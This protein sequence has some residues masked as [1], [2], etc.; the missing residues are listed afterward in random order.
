MYTVLKDYFSYSGKSGEDGFYNLIE[1]CKNSMLC[2]KVIL[3][4]F[5]DALKTNSILQ[6][7]GTFTPI[8]DKIPTQSSLN[9]LLEFLPEEVKDPMV[10]VFF[11]QW[12]NATNADIENNAWYVQT[13]SGSVGGAGVPV[14]L[15]TAVDFVSAAYYT[16][17]YNS[18]QHVYS[19]K[20]W[21]KSVIPEKLP[22]SD[23]KDPPTKDDV[24]TFF[25][26]L[27]TWI[28]ENDPLV[29][30]LTDL[31]DATT[32]GDAN[33][34]LAAV[35]GIS[36]IANVDIPD[37]CIALVNE[38]EA[39]N[40][41]GAHLSI[42]ARRQLIRSSLTEVNKG[43]SIWKTNESLQALANQYT[44]KDEEYW[45]SKIP[46]VFGLI[47]ELFYTGLT[48]TNQ[49]D[50]DSVR[51]SI[52]QIFKD[53]QSSFSITAY[54][55][56]ELK[57]T[58]TEQIKIVNPD[59]AM[60]D[61]WSDEIDDPIPAT[62]HYA[63]IELLMKSVCNTLQDIPLTYTKGGKVNLFAFSD[64]DDINAKTNACAF[65]SGKNATD[66][67]LLNVYADAEEFEKSNVSG[68]PVVIDQPVRPVYGVFTN[69]KKTY[70]KFFNMG[71]NIP[72]GSFYFEDSSNPTLV[73]TYEYNSTTPLSFDLGANTINGETEVPSGGLS[74]VTEGGITKAMPTGTKFREQN[75]KSV[76]KKNFYAAVRLLSKWKNLN[77]QRHYEVLY[78]TIPGKAD[79]EVHLIW[80]VASGNLDRTDKIDD[81]LCLWQWLVSADHRHAYSRLPEIL[82][83]P[84]NREI[85][86]YSVKQIWSG[87]SMQA[88]IGGEPF[89]V[90]DLPDFKIAD[91]NSTG[92]AIYKPNTSQPFQ[93]YVETNTPN[94][95]LP[96]V[97]DE[98][99]KRDT[100]KGDLSEEADLILQLF[101]FSY[102]RRSTNVGGT[103]KVIKW[104]PAKYRPNDLDD[105]IDLGDKGQPQNKSAIGINKPISLRSNN[106]ALHFKK[107]TGSDGP[108]HTS[109]KNKGNP[110]YRA[111][112]KR[113]PAGKVMAKLKDHV[114]G[115]LSK[116]PIKNSSLSATEFGDWVLEN[117]EDYV[118]EEWQEL[119]MT[120][121]DELPT[122]Q[123]WCHL[124]GHGDSGDERL[125]NF[126]SGSFHCNTEQLAM[127][128]K[129]R[130]SI[131]QS[132]PKGTYQLRS[133][134]Y[135]FNDNKALL[136][137]DYLANEAAYQKMVKVYSAL[138]VKKG[139]TMKLTGAGT[140]MPLAA[141][142][143]YKIYGSFDS[144]GE[145]AA[146]GSKVE[147]K[148]FDHIFEGQS[149]FIDQHQFN[150]LKHAAWFCVAGKD[151]FDEWYRNEVSALEAK[152]AI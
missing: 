33:A 117:S 144:D 65:P 66:S 128:S 56:Q 138:Q 87:P 18:L 61:E 30:A 92:I 43:G 142:L 71:S 60:L 99:L 148:L 42:G 121:R 149:E 84:V 109:L 74:G 78:S 127:E 3:E 8:P 37:F 140:V 123:E 41:P 36:P 91:F 120:Q 106:N 23:T 46:K 64:Y 107:Y 135:L 10:Q 93:L 45:R 113:E 4:L 152:M 29:I 67:D 52:L 88:R 69:S 12:D 53:F 132:A 27:K 47:N 96:S 63:D 39:T 2:H 79:H 28:K 89:Y 70:F 143:R 145:D 11:E 95:N 116:F 108:A 38:I 134:A 15:Q 83:L 122:N 97:I 81:S 129:E 24:I 16:G 111:K 35:F 147:T 55:F 118:L 103:Y 44:A 32:Y 82:G 9:A 137:D 98:M 102:Y 40:E 101:N 73:Q 115:G 17:E 77:G 133:T 124:L 125:G 22:N 14:S 72:D 21:T 5:M 34:I 20:G 25:G 31:Q 100:K 104:V 136:K 80:Y 51:A 54:L 119:K 130:R 6:R 7:T 94:P 58:C 90:D 68:D 19:Q 114:S 57:N 50:A 13:Y 139:K 151:A 110:L 48:L 146:A 105:G 59:L 126:V 85:V 150:I 62:I 141:F 26:K 49:T 86:A 131:T 112:A 75:G 76:S 1:D